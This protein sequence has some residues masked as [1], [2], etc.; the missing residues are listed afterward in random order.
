M[1]GKQEYLIEAMDGHDRWYIL[2]SEK[3]NG[4]AQASMHSY[5]KLFARL[6]LRVVEHPS[7]VLMVLNDPRPLD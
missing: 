1:M 4:F 3:T 2:G 6:P 7:R 5:R